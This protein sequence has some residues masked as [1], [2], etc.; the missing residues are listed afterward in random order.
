MRKKPGRILVVGG[1]AGGA[2]A[3]ARIRRLDEKC[4]IIMFERG[5]HVSFSNCALPFHLSG[6]IPDHKDLVLMTP[7]DFYKNYRI[8]ARINSEVVAIDREKKEVR[9]K[10]LETGEEYSEPYDKLILSPGANPLI[11]P[12]EGLD[13]VNV[14]TIRNVADI[15]KLNRFIKENDCQK[16]AVIGGGFIGIEAAEN[17]RLAGYEVTVVEAMPQILRFFDYDMVQIFQKELIDKGID[18][19][20]G[21]K[22]KKF[23]RN[24]VILESGREIKAEA[25]VV[26]IGVVPE[27]TLAQK[28]GLKIGSTGAIAVDQN[29]R[30]SDKDIYAVGDAIE[31]YNSLL[32][33]YSKLALAGLAQ[34]QARAAA[35][36]IYG[37]VVNNT[38]VIGTSVIKVFDYNGASTGLTEGLIKAANMQ[39]NYDSVLIIPNDKVGIMP[40]SAPLFFKLIFEV[41][42]GRVLGA[43]AIGKGNVDKR[44]DVIATLIK[45]NGTL[46]DLKDL[47]LCYAP[48]FGTAKDVVNIA[49]LVGL[50]ILHGC[51]K[52]VHVHEVRKLVEE[53]ACIID[54]RTP[55]EFA[56][57][58]IINT[59]NIPLSEIRERLEEIPKDRPVYLYCRSGQRSYYGVM[60]L[61]HLGFENVYNVSGSFLGLSFYE[62]YNDKSQDRKPIVTEYNFE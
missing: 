1:V 30:T 40:D 42:T 62:Y 51:Y 23:E 55:A 10:N 49:A 56:K 5:P 38:G 29:F 17:L 37:R 19:I 32:R 20:V 50:N 60:A 6:L 8:E 14:F 61:Q 45:L 16:I 59:K 22:V 24:T 3:A 9:V 21:D 36:H 58:H 57:G 18:L 13:L 34:K 48:S 12:W 53:G 27:T 47:E 46:E 26:A 28:A 44:I 33:T 54:V 52:Q 31:V 15:S 4:E 39:I 7:E 11:P 41:P 35:D 2:S 25:V 43:Q